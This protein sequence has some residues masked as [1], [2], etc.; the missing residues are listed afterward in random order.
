MKQ[1]QRAD[2]P[3]EETSGGRATFSKLQRHPIFSRTFEG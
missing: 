2:W 1:P 3:G